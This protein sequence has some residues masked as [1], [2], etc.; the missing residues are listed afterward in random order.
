MKQ[1]TVTGFSRARLGRVCFFAISI[2]FLV[3]SSRPWAAG[4]VWP[5]SDTVN[6]A[7]ADFKN[8]PPGA[9]SGNFTLNKYIY[10]GNTTFT[11]LS[12]TLTPSTSQ[13]SSWSI[14]VPILYVITIG[15]SNS[16]QASLVNITLR[17]GLSPS[18][19]DPNFVIFKIS[20]DAFNGA[21]CPYPSSV[22]APGTT[23]P[24]DVPNIQIKVGTEVV[25]R[26]EGYYKTQG[27]FQNTFSVFETGKQATTEEQ[28]PPKNVQITNNWSVIDLKLSKTSSTNSTSVSATVPATIHYKLT[29]T[30]DSSHDFYPA[31]LLRIQDAIIASHPPVPSYSIP[32]SSFT[33]SS[34]NGS[35]C[36]TAPSPLN[37]NPSSFS[38]TNVY[39]YTYLDWPTA[40]STVIKK[41]DTLTIEFDLN[42]NAGGC[43]NSSTT[44][45]NQASFTGISPFTYSDSNNGNNYNTPTTQ[46]SF[47]TGL[48]P[49]PPAPGP[50]G[51]ITKTLVCPSSGCPIFNWG[52]T[53]TYEV[54]VKN[55]LATAQT[56]QVTDFVSKQSIT[57]PVRATLVPTTSAADVNCFP[58]ICTT[59]PDA[60]LPPFVQDVFVD[61]VGYNLF[62]TKFTLQPS[63]SAGGAD[64]LTLT[65]NMKIDKLAEC[66]TDPG[67]RFYNQ[68]TLYV[69]AAN[70][71]TAVATV[72]AAHVQLPELPS[73][74]LRVQKTLD[75]PLN[76]VTFG[77]P[78]SYTV[79]YENLGTQPITVRTLRD[80]L[81]V[82]DTLNSNSY[83]NIPI[84]NLTANCTST[85]GV[86]PMPSY[87]LGHTQIY[88]AGASWVG[89]TVI[90]ETSNT[91][92]ITFPGGSKLQCTVSFTPHAPSATDNY[93]K[94]R[95]LPE[96]VNNAFMDVSAIQ[97]GIAPSAPYFA[98]ATAPLPL[99]RKV[100]V[101]K[102]ID[103]GV[104]STGPNGLL[105]F[106]IQVTNYGNDPV[107]NF[108]LNDPLPAGFT[109]NG[110]VNCIPTTA[111]AS[112]AFSGT[113]PRVLNAVFNPIPPSP[114][115]KVTLTFNVNASAAGGTYQNTA[116]GSFGPGT[117]GTN[118]YFEGD[119]AVLLVNS[120]Q[121][122]VLT[123]TL[124]KSFQPNS[125]AVNGSAV[126][127]FN[128]T[129]QT[130][131]PAQTGISFTDLMPSGITVTS[132]PSTACGGSISVSGGNSITLSNGALAQ[133]QHQ[134]QFAVNVKASS[135]GAFVNDQTNFSHVTNLDVTNAKD[136][137]TV[138]GCPPPDESCPVK[139][140]EISCKSDGSGGYLYTFTVTNNT[141][142]VVTD[143][144][145]TPPANSNLTLSPPQLSLLPAGLAIGASLT[146]QVTV[147]GGQPEQPACFYV[148]LMTKDG[149]CCTTRVCPVLPEC[150]AVIK[151][152][153]IECNNDGTFTHTL[154]IVNT[155]VNTIEHIY[156]YPPPGVTMTPNYFAVS[157]KAGD[158]FTTKVTIKGAKPG[159]KLCFGISLHTANMENC[160]QGEQCIVLPACPDSGSRRP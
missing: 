123:P 1:S 53:V 23:L 63:G 31:N 7:E 75:S 127:T 25:V 98:Q 80:A 70:S 104:T 145:L 52:D 84:T 105:T 124:T 88:P 79:T 150:C 5:D 29:L 67:N 110:L 160:C 147:N 121:V 51:T 101:V 159:D 43:G 132:A 153:S 69:V 55:N 35:T 61:S 13:I 118:F 21:A 16:A 157:L 143:I 30:G 129:N 93:C 77:Q 86:S 95:G 68:A 33:C 139:T 131:D 96:I 82:R 136:T 78:V 135:C 48:L 87:Q 99:C 120:A 92:G 74:D 155:G 10:P 83:G 44:I 59:T 40:S 142:H 50:P 17:D 24:L 107:S 117:P 108:L 102:T 158:T 91:T 65:F 103:G 137:L 14:G 9:T 11:S 32:N 37:P 156:L 15:N 81:N 109:D 76:G 138:T 27:S 49:C 19:L 62:H 141:G 130:S 134:C 114:N 126:L 41:G 64:S 4:K 42:V 85:T 18:T 100:G 112:A 26:I 66:D 58:A 146:L 47:T 22:P 125:I 122:Q 45:Q 148:T 54:V 56:F 36:P 128:I 34:V 94:G 2:L 71:N 8:K 152:E 89:L 106:Q 12:P 97:E 20:C 38:G 154:S 90:Y 149:E 144:L 39:A 57:V 73:C 119:Q 72:L 3:S 60:A 46:N 28:G 116:I 115:N 151:E 111:C 6:A 140:N 113:S 133:G